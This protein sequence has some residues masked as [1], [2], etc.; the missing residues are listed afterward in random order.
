IRLSVDSSRIP[1]TR[2]TISQPLQ[3]PGTRVELFDHLVPRRD[4]LAHLPPEALWPPGFE[5]LERHALL[6]DPR[7]VPQVE[8]ALAI[9]VGQLEQVVGGRP[10]NVPAERS[11]RRHPAEPSAEVPRHDLLLLAPVHGRTDGGDRPYALV[12]P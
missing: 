3:R 5:L 10:Q 12:G 9:Q 6:L 11:T 2:E 4:D 1:H 7:E 8:D